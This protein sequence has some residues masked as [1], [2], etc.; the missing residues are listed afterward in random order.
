MTHQPETLPS[1][2]GLQA[3][4]GGGEAVMKGVSEE[5]VTGLS[6]DDVW[7]TEQ[8]ETRREGGKYSNSDWAQVDE[9]SLLRILVHKHT[10]NPTV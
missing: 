6:G 7:R 3:G 4:G 9:R 8:K 1:V 2:Q 10:L 5:N